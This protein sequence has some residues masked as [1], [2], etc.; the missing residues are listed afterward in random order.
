MAYQKKHRRISLPSLAK[1]HALLF[2]QLFSELFLNILKVFQNGI[3]TELHTLDLSTTE[4]VLPGSHSWLK[5]ILHTCGYTHTHVHAHTHIYTHRTYVFYLIFF[6]I[7]FERNL[8][9]I[10]QQRPKTT[11]V[12]KR[13]FR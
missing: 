3:Y 7:S 11:V 12:R 1:A 9:P 2:Y 4:P 10:A 8:L 6:L 5:V 13:S